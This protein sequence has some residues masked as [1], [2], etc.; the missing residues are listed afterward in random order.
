MKLLDKCE[1]WCQEHYLGTMKALLGIISAVPTIGLF[2]V[3]QAYYN[4]NIGDLLTCLFIVVGGTVITTLFALTVYNE[5]QDERYGSIR[6][7]PVAK[8]VR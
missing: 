2:G 8:R 7:H 5:H 6:R 1:N 3:V 4:S